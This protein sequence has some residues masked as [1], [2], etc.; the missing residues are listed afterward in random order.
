MTFCIP[1]NWNLCKG[2]S[3]PAYGGFCCTIH[4]TSLEIK[5]KQKL[6]EGRIRAALFSWYQ[7]NNVKPSER[8]LDFNLKMIGNDMDASDSEAYAHPGCSASLKAAETGYL[9]KFGLDYLQRM[10]DGVPFK[11][12]LITAGTAALTF[13]E[14]LHNAPDVVP[15]ET[16]QVLFDKMQCF[17]CHYSDA[18]LNQTPKLHMLMHLV[19]R[20]ALLCINLKGNCKL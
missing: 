7:D 18:G 20:T 16:C 6:G 12:A 9:A 10:G 5:K 4:G 1:F 19:H 15:L 8:L 13:W 17:V 2:G 3:L 11:D 14:L